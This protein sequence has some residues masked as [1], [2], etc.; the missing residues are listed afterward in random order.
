MSGHWIGEEVQVKGE[1]GVIRYIGQVEFAEGN[2]VGIELYDVVGRNDGSAK[3]KRYFNC[4]KQGNYGVFAK[5]AIVHN[6]EKEK[7]SMEVEK[8]ELGGREHQIEQAGQTNKEMDKPA[9]AK[10]EIESQMEMLTVEKDYL[11]QGNRQLKQELEDLQVKYDIACTELQ[12][13]QEEKQLNQQIETE[14]KQQLERRQLTSEDA[15]FLMA[16]NKQLE[17]ALVNLRQFSCE[18]KRNLVNQFERGEGTT[19]QTINESAGD[20]NLLWENLQTA[21]A[22]I[23]EL[24]N[25]LDAA[26]ELEKIIE[27]LN[28]QND[29][30]NKEIND[31]ANTVMQLKELHELD[32]GLAETQTLI[33]RDLQGELN[34]LSS[35]IKED[36][37]QIY[38]LKKSNKDLE[39]KIGHLQQKEL[40][41]GEDKKHGLEINETLQT[42]REDLE[43]SRLTSFAKGLLLDILEG[44]VEILSRYLP[45]KEALG[46]PHGAIVNC[47]IKLEEI[48]TYVRRLHSYFN[49]QEPSYL[50][51][52]DW[53]ARQFE[54]ENL[55][56]FIETLLIFWNL[57]FSSDVYL[58]K[59]PQFETLLPTLEAD[60]VATITRIVSHETNFISIEFV[61]TFIK[62]TQILIP[63]SFLETDATM[64][65][66]FIF[67]FLRT[68]VNESETSK[69]IFDDL[70]T[71]L[72]S[73]ENSNPEARGLLDDTKGLQG[74]CEHLIAIFLNLWLSFKA[75]KDNGR[76][77]SI[78]TKS[79]GEYDFQ[80]NCC[81]H[82]IQ[83]LMPI[84]SQVNSKKN[85][86][87]LSIE[88]VLSAVGYRDHNAFPLLE[89]CRERFKLLS[90]LD[91]V[92]AVEL[93]E[94]KR[95]LMDLVTREQTEYR[96]REDAFS[97]LTSVKENLTMMSDQLLLKDKAID[98]L[99]VKIGTLRNNMVMA[100]ERY[101]KKYTDLEGEMRQLESKH[102]TVK[103][104]YRKV[105]ERNSLLQEEL[106]D[107]FSE[108]K[109][110]RKQGNEKGLNLRSEIMI[111]TY[112][113]MLNEVKTLRNLFI[114]TRL[115]YERKN[116]SSSTDWLASDLFQIREKPKSDPFDKLCTYARHLASNTCIV[117]VSSKKCWRPLKESTRYNTLLTEERLHK[118]YRRKKDLLRNNNN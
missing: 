5:E 52:G 66:V 53:V 41:A 34:Q 33:E 85:R 2:W 4:E 89:A 84:I 10:E 27:H 94:S 17:M 68:M 65:H 79:I 92:E 18:N 115:E 50:E 59:L 117:Q 55:G 46:M 36:E 78:H 109:P 42:L 57:N 40:R 26:L 96:V 101:K 58:L 32:K 23:K 83:F 62:E 63:L 35:K 106:D 110:K 30:L 80:K 45:L 22:N 118:F 12:I 25:Q 91:C 1:R 70:V 24:Q 15:E 100:D 54:L 44:K 3:G 29:K 11:Q 13:M 114:R 49:K 74:E 28:A 39:S 64:K 48:L 116:L 104:N 69:L 102:G 73:F 98:E 71:V 107:L 6:A 97:E 90:N 105:H 103:D 56:I 81:N 86:K 72:E 76:L 112:M 14:I 60:L 21:E 95:D 82:F 7:R 93:D 75:I 16:K 99:Q 8:R 31:L 87:G 9:Q 20:Y 108:K 51:Y 47:M 77:G 37:A 19:A 67:Y 113:A 43:Q 61:E 38:R 88:V 111:N